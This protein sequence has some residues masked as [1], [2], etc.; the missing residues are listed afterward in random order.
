M[1]VLRIGDEWV[2]ASVLRGPR[3]EA[4]RDPQRLLESLRKAVGRSIV[5]VF[6]AGCVVSVRQIHAAA[7]AAYLAFRAGT[8][9]SRKFELE[10]LLRLAADTQIGRVLER[11]AVKPGTREVGYCVAAESGER[12]LE[13]SRAAERIIGGSAMSEEELRRDERLRRAMKFYGISEEE[14]EAV[15]ATDR[16]EAVL[17]LVLERIATLDLKRR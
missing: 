12:A 15:Q 3:P 14:V 6:D 2:S 8:N 11:L 17:I 7:A 16:A 10:L 9:I 5:Q 4:L 1:I 13:C